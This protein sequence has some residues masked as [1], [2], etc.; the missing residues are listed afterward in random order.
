[1]NATSGV[2]CLMAGHST[3]MGACKQHVLLQGKTFLEHILTT[4][5]AVGREVW[6]PRIFVGS[7]SDVVGRAL[8]EERG[9]VWVDNHEV[10]L[11]PLHSIRLALPLLDSA[12]G[13]FLWPVDHP[14]ICPET[15]QMLLA[16]VGENPERIVVPSY[17]QR[18]GH[19]PRFPA[20]TFALLRQAPLEAGARWVLHQC[21]AAV[22]H[23][24][25]TDPWVVK[26]L[27]TP[28]RLAEAEVALGHTS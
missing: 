15:L 22:F 4:L 27:N 8:I 1:M 28:E 13:F 3:R 11:G 26:N 21:P 12:G 7:P 16:A 5:D 25:V 6:G 24:E 17:A 18:R 19:P 9:G 23:V 20:P 10:E 2:V 14:L